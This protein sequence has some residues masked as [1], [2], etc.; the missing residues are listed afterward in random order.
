MSVVPE[1]NRSW[2]LDEPNGL[3]GAGKSIVR[4]GGPAVE[5]IAMFPRSSLFPSREQ[6]ML[7]T[8]RY[9]YLPI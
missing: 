8:K 6:T 5:W 2:E 1:G 7:A 4:I 9:E 3:A